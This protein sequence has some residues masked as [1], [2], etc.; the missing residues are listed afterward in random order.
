MTEACR[1]EPYQLPPTA[2]FG[3]DGFVFRYFDRKIVRFAMPGLK[4]NQTLYRPPHTNLMKAGW[5]RDRMASTNE[6]N[7]TNHDHD[8][9]IVI[10]VISVHEQ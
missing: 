5:R 3:L 9:E 2:T 6:I 4:W 1:K 10:M 7:E 8:H